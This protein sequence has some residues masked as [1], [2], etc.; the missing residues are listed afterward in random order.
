MKLHINSPDCAWSESARKVFKWRDI[1]SC[2]ARAAYRQ[3]ADHEWGLRIDSILS[4]LVVFSG[5]N[6]SVRSTAKNSTKQMRSR[7]AV[8]GLSRLRMCTRIDLSLV[9]LFQS[10]KTVNLSDADA[11]HISGNSF[12]SVYSLSAASSSH[13][14]FA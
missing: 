5:R 9:S 12:S 4:A 2:S 10:F 8:D 11:C 7:G 1:M 14:A 3:D 13:V 6:R